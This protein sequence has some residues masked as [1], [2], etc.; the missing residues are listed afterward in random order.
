MSTLHWQRGPS[1]DRPRP[2]RSRHSRIHHKPNQSISIFSLAQN[3]PHP[4]GSQGQDFQATRLTPPTTAPHR[5]R[6]LEKAQTKTRHRIFFLYN[7]TSQA[8]FDDI[9]QATNRGLEA[10]D[11][12]QRGAA[13][14]CIMQ[15]LDRGMGFGDGTHGLVIVGYLLCMVMNFESPSNAVSIHGRLGCVCV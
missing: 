1:P 6:G 7:C 5:P 3:W 15:D 8:S 11:L 10:L 2:A 9:T 14:I 13:C 12:E 4:A